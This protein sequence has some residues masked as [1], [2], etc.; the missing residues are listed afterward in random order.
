MMRNN[1]DGPNGTRV[2]VPCVSTARPSPTLTG[3]AGQLWVL[4]SDAGSR[5]AFESPQSAKTIQGF[6][7]EYPVQGSRSEQFKQIGNAVPP[8][9]AAAVVGALVGGR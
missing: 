5:P 9:L 2:P 7:P 1:T 3:L 8:P 4:H 6:C